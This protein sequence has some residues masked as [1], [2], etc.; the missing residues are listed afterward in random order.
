MDNKKSVRRLATMVD[1]S[2]NAVMNVPSVKRSGKN[3]LPKADFH[4]ITFEN[5]SFKY[6]GDLPYV[7]K[8]VNLDVKAGDIWETTTFYNITNS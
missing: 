4:E 7:F 6:E 5:V 2:R 3:I 8:N 1:C